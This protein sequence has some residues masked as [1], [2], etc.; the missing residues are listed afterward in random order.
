MDTN[1]ELM[2]EEHIN[3][4]LMV[5][6]VTEFQE[7]NEYYIKFYDPYYSSKWNGI[8]KLDRELK[9]GFNASGFC[10]RS[11]FP[12]EE[13]ALGKTRDVRT[14]VQYEFNSEN[15]TQVTYFK[16]NALSLCNIYKLTKTDYILK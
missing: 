5:T 14:I 16:F 7:G 12:V 15:T 3:E 8:Y 9:L 4:E 10:F 11:T 13:I 6:D 1:I 2:D